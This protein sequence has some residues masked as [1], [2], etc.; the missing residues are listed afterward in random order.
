MYELV[1]VLAVGLFLARLPTTSALRR[2]LPLAVLTLLA[3]D[4]NPEV[5]PYGRPIAVYRQMVEAPIQIDPSCRSFFIKGASDRY[6]AR[7]G[8]MWSLYGIDA[9]FI[10]IDHAMPTLNGYSAWEPAGWGLANPQEPAYPG[11]VSEWIERHDLQGVCALD[12]EARSM[13]PY[14]PVPAPR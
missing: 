6:M 13:T 9:M 7:S 5:F 4:W 10:A 14:G 8:H 12:I 1:A 11:R 2:A 3:A